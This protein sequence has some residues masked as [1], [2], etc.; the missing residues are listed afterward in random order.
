MKKVEYS[1]AIIQHNCCPCT[2]TLFERFSAFEIEDAESDI[3]L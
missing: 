1:Y 3:L 2:H